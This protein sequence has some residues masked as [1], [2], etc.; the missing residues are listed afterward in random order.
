MQDFI[1]KE[2]LEDVGITLVGDEL[3]ALLDHLNETLEDRVGEEIIDALED[4]QLEAF[5]KLQE[6]STDEQVFAWIQQNVPDYEQIVKTETDI[7]LGET[8]QNVTGVNNA[9]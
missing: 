1:T 9:T 5:M 6:S 4:D 3:T 7:L 2:T 8:S